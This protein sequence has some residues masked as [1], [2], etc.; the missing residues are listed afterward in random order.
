MGGIPST[1]KLNNFIQ[2]IST[3]LKPFFLK[4]IQNRPLL[5][6]HSVV[7]K[8]SSCWVHTTSR[9]GIKQ[10]GI[11]CG[12]IFLLFSNKS[13]QGPHS[14]QPGKILALPL[15]DRLGCKSVKLIQL[16]AKYSFVWPAWQTLSPQQEDHCLASQLLLSVGKVMEPL[17]K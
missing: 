13:S 14:Q 2:A 4:F 16:F 6:S 10:L 5:L 12:S 3:K 11:S 17:D 15:N 8:I 7:T 1:L 9:R